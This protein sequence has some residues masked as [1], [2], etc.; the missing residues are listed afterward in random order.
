[1]EEEK[2]MFEGNGLFI[3]NLSLG[4]IIF[5]KNYVDKLLEFIYFYIYE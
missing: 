3:E 1:M 5:D 4:M 2:N